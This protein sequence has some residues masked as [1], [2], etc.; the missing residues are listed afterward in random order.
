VQFQVNEQNY[1]LDFIPEEGRW[2]LI[3]PTLSGIETL[4]VVD[5]DAPGLSENGIAVP[6]DIEVV[7]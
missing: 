4:P 2:F 7:N 3:K 6:L 1:F 5:D